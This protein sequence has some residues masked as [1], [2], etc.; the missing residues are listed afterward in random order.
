MY[1]KLLKILSH[2]FLFSILLLSLTHPPH[3]G[4]KYSSQSLY[5]NS[6]LLDPYNLISLLWFSETILTMQLLVYTHASLLGILAIPFADPFLFLFLH[7]LQIQTAIIT[8]VD[9]CFLTQMLSG[10]RHMFLGYFFTLNLK[11]KIILHI[12]FS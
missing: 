8:P 12:T 1:K 4:E 6:I 9:I 10:N 3:T 7:N 11:I 5:I 2:F